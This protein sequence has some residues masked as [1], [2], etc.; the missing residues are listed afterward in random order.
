VKAAIALLL[1]VP[2]LAQLPGGSTESQKKAAFIVSEYANVLRAL[3]AS[4]SESIILA[5]EAALATYAQVASVEADAVFRQFWSFYRRV[6]RD[7]VGT[8]FPPLY[9][10]IPGNRLLTEACAGSLRR[11][12]GSDV[13]AFLRSQ[14]PDHVRLREANREAA[15]LLSGYRAS[16]IAFDWNEGS[17]YV[18]VDP[19]FLLATAARLPLGE[20]ADWVRFWAAEEP[21]VVAEDA[22]L[23][24]GWDDVRLRLARWERF[25]RAHP[26]L[27]ETEAEVI[28]HVRQLLALY[29]FGTSNTP[30]YNPSIDPNLK[31]SYDRFLVENRDS[32]FYTVVQGIV[33][34]VTRSSG[35][36][37]PDLVSFLTSQL[38][39]PYFKAWLRGAERW[40]SVK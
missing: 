16:G 18:R 20:L 7:V 6:V 25:G 30:A 22:S 12:R 40:L 19:D 3:D 39:H 21:Q 26:E 29:V 33:E 35:R 14:R 17:W 34:R 32:N 4:K 31:A 9:G 27:P 28:P 23:M 37:T 5:R 10:R 13:D 11:C 2:G 1:A 38:R 24:V 8:A 36:A 15:E